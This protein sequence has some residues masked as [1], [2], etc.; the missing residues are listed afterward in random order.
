MRNWSVNE[1]PLGGQETKVKIRTRTVSLHRID[2]GEGRH[3][4]YSI[5]V[6][7]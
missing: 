1:R 7:D 6:S 4:P 5:I 2:Y 3:C